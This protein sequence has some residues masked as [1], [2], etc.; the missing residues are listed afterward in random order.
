MAL[1]TSYMASAFATPAGEGTGVVADQQSSLQAL[2]A[3][4]VA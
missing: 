1:F 4:P 3:K 2:L